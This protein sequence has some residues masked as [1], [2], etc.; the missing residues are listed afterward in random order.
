MADNCKLITPNWDAPNHVVAFT[1]TRAGGCSAAPFNRLNL[2]T[3][4][5]DKL[6]DVEQ[7]R[8]ILRNELSLPNEP[9]W[10]N[11]V[12]QATVIEVN[13]EQLLVDAD[14]SFSREAQQICTVLTADCLPILLTNR[15]GTEVAAIHAGWRSL[16]GGIIENT[17]AQLQSPHEELIAWLGPAICGNCYEVGNEVYDA[18]TAHDSTAAAIFIETRENHWLANLP[19]LAQRRLKKLKI[20]HI[21]CSNRCTLEEPELFFSYRR[22]G[23]TG[24]M[25][26]MI[27]MS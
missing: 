24:R 14:A 2:G 11:Q 4:S 15:Q 19:A 22:D 27:Y 5:G 21:F 7:N 9:A 17:V 20:E 6:A 12:H 16:A 26:S 1:T 13:D 10:L 25:A 8:G 18:F 23:A 3:N